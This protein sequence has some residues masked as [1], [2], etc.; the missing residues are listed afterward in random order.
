MYS[1]QADLANLS[2]SLFSY[3]LIEYQCLVRKQSTSSLVSSIQTA[4]SCWLLG[5]RVRYCSQI[6]TTTIPQSQGETQNK[7][8]WSVSFTHGAEDLPHHHSAH[9]SIHERT[10]SMSES[11]FRQVQLGSKR[12]VNTKLIANLILRDYCHEFSYPGQLRLPFH[13]VYLGKR[14]GRKTVKTR[15]A[16]W[17]CV[18]G[19]RILAL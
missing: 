18:P 5:K 7:F 19:W 9:N 6:T 12:P 14:R 17:P 16:N 13:S 10:D 1:I 3:R 11:I 4:Q 2:P 15:L 8:T